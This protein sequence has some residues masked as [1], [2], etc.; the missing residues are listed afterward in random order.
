VGVNEINWK[1]VA[2]YILLIVVLAFIASYIFN[3]YGFKTSVNAA[4]SSLNLKLPALS[5]NGVYDFLKQ[6]AALI[7]VAA[8]LGVT[9]VTYFVK[10]YQTNKLLNQKIE[11]LTD[12]KL[13]ISKTAEDKIVALQ[14]Q[15]DDASNDTTADSLQTQLSSV[16]SAKDTLETRYSESQKMIKALQEQLDA[17]PVIKT[18]EYK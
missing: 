14:K 3:I 6:N 4:F 5:L 1:G 11:E 10:N 15:L 7:G 8:P 12:T 16:K 18:V 17:R 13:S 2:Y 9:A